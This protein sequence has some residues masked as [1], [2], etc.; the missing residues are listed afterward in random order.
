MIEQLALLVLKRL[1]LQAVEYRFKVLSRFGIPTLFLSLLISFSNVLAACG[2]PT[3]ETLLPMI[4]DYQFGK[5]KE[6]SDLREIELLG[7]HRKDLLEEY[8]LVSH[9]LW[10]VSFQPSHLKVKLELEVY[11]LADSAGA[12]GLFS[13]WNDLTNQSLSSRLDLP[14]DNHHDR[15]NLIFWS[16]NYLFFLKDPSRF[17]S[18]E[19][20]LRSLASRLRE[21][22]SEPTVHPLSIVHLPRE[23]LILKSTRFYL[24]Q[25][26]LRVNRHLP[27]SLRPV[28][29]FGHHAEAA[30]AQYGP[31]DHFLFLIS[32]PTPA[33]ADRYFYKLYYAL[34]SYA[35]PENI[36]LKRTGVIVCIFLGPEVKARQLFSQIKYLPSIQWIYEKHTRSHQPTSDEVISLLLV[37]RDSLLSTGFFMVC[38]LAGG[39]A[40]GLIRYNL[41]TRLPDLSR[42]NELIRLRI[43]DR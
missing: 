34:Q 32:Y 23:N 9:S 10:T 26:S 2:Q 40:T 12:F 36:Y 14:F 20:N 6:T 11:E 1:T 25:T 38:T 33:L 5:I 4:T 42:K 41:L 15:Q 43:V 17:S 31:E 37:V 8:R 13:L 24:G 22:I 16:G 28:I 3:I 35:S 7:P 29:G 27:Q 30:F 19:D 39:L 18:G 21:I